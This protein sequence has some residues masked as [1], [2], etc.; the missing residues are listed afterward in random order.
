MRSPGG[1]S[2]DIGQASPDLRTDIIKI[3]GFE[4]SLVVGEAMRRGMS[5]AEW[6]SLTNLP[7]VSLTQTDRAAILAE[8]HKPRFSVDPKLQG[9]QD[10]LDKTL[11]LEQMTAA[12][13]DAK[14]VAAEVDAF[15]FD[16]SLI[17][18]AMVTTLGCASCW[19]S[20]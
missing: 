9:V 1:F 7:Y 14:R 5:P 3:G 19:R 11:S 2:D 6:T 18:Q 17:E 16:T 10:A 15:S 12:E 8:E 4:T 20:S 13:A